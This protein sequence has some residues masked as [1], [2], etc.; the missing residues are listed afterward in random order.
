[1]TPSSSSQAQGSPPL[2]WPEV[3][4]RIAPVYE[5]GL[6]FFDDLPKD[7]AESVPPQF[8]GDRLGGFDTTVAALAALRGPARVST[9]MAKIAPSLAFVIAQ[10]GPE[11]DRSRC[12]AAYFTLSYMNAARCCGGVVPEDAADVELVWIEQLAA[13]S[14]DLPE[15]DRH[16][17]ALAACAAGRG[18]LVPTFADLKALDQSFEPGKTFGFNVPAFAGYLGTA[19]ERGASYQDVELAWLDF[20]HRFPYKLE[21]NTLSWPA[22]LWA[23]RAVYA[24]LGGL[25]ENEV[26]AELHKLLTNA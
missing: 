24:T 2:T 11:L 19:V 18:D 4:D 12:L 6:F 3:I 17:A 26:A 14:R 22:L 20:V 13:R 1:M 23:A 21:A 16:T 10:V 7:I 8:G 25:P 15:R 9:I 5:E